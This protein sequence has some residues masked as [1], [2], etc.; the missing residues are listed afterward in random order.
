MDTSWPPHLR[1]PG[2]TV[3]TVRANGLDFE[4][5]EMGAGDRVALLLHGFP[6]LAFSWRYQMPLLAGMGWRVWAPNLRGYGAST[7]P[8]GIAAY[9]VDRLLDDVVALADAAVPSELLLIAHDWGGALAWQFAMRQLRPLVGLAV[10]NMPHPAGFGRALRTPRQLARS[11]YTLFFQLPWLPEALLARGG[12]EGVRRAFAD[13][14]RDKAMFPADV[15]DVYA[16]AASRPGALTAMINWYR[17]A[18]GDRSLVSPGGAIATRTLLIWGEADTA[19]GLDT[20]AG[21]ERDVPGIV[22]HRL[23]GVS[24]WVQ[25]E[26]PARVNAILEAWICRLSDETGLAVV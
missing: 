10:M 23:P 3:R 15:L 4:L 14:A 21:V 7:R 13:M 16:A 6:E 24:H 1:P 20:I 25:Q 2:L 9:R 5:A 12:G 11:W 8:T 18:R 19:L 17:G 26:A 22:V